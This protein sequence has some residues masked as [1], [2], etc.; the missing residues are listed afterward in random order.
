MF[1]YVSFR[2][3]TKRYRVAS[4]CALVSGG[5]GQFEVHTGDVV[6]VPGSVDYT[7]VNNGTETLHLET[8]EPVK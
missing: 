6:V 7:I 5:R 4:G 2:S 1:C 3:E 8:V